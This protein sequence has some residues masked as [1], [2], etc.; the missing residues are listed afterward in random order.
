MGGKK[1]KIS[2]WIPQGFSTTS[3]KGNINLMPK[4]G[5]YF[6]IFL[7]LQQTKKQT[8]FTLTQCQSCLPR[9][10]IY[11]KMLEFKWNT[12]SRAG[13]G[14]G[15][16]SYFLTILKVDCKKITRPKSEPWV[17]SHLEWPKAKESLYC[18]Y[19]NTIC[20]VPTQTVADARL[21]Q[22]SS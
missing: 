22:C 7:S 10:C 15:I 9:I 14:S 12:N 21:C 13:S 17:N 2:P 8:G 11:K 19:F 18:T 20:T 1:K 16:F 3:I 6:I 4:L 5:F